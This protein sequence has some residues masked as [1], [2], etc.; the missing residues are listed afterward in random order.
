MT[1]RT[2]IFKHGESLI[3]DSG[4]NSIYSFSIFA[5]NHNIKVKTGDSLYFLDSDLKFAHVVRGFQEVKSVYLGI[6]IRGYN[7]PKKMNEINF[8]T[9]LPYVNGCSARQIF[10]PERPGDPTWQLLYMPSKTKEQIHHVH[11]TPRIAFVLNGSGKAVFG[12]K[13]NY[14]EKK[15]HDKD[16]CCIETMTPHHFEADEDLKIL[17]F[18]V[19]S[20]VMDKLELNHPMYTGTIPVVT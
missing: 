15:I 13:S 8:H 1:F 5:G 3:I 12:S 18:H 4:E 16:I 20:T 17:A 9:F 6:L 2:S 10:P 11:S 14:I 19:F 7:S